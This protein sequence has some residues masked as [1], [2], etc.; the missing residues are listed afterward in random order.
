MSRNYQSLKEILEAG[1]ASYRATDDLHEAKGHL[2]GVQGHFK[3]LLL[4]REQREELYNRLQ[5][6]FAEVNLLIAGE[7][8]A[9]E[10]EALA[11]HADLAPLVREALA[12]ASELE[13]TRMAWDRLLSLQDRLKEL[14]LLREHRDE[15]FRQLREG[16]DILKMRREEARRVADLDARQHY[17]RLRELVNKGLAQAEESHEYK[18]T[19]EFLKKIQAEFKGVRMA[20]E[21][22]EE[23]YSR[24]QTAFDIL[25]KRL[26]DYFRNKKKNWAVRMEFS[27]SRLTADIYRLEQEIGKDEAYLKE[28]EDQLEIIVSSGKETDA[29]VSVESRIAS[30]HR[31][32]AYRRRQIAEL[33]EEKLKLQ[34]KISEPPDN[35]QPLP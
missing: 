28:L 16:F 20:P 23:L 11:N 12:Q 9:F 30:T 7:K 4:H 2:I 31:N 25:G 22:R 15:M 6:A 32:L 3:G 34:Q 35:A 26:D 1:L 5:E 8:N 10:L 33:E 17:T 21:Q 24:L 18:E 19:R 14:K 29:A 27:I 13:D